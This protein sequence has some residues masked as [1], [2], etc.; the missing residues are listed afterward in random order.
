MHLM[1]IRSPAPLADAGPDR[2]TAAARS[3]YRWLRRAGASVALLLACAAPAA[4]QNLIVNAGFE[5]NPPPANG[6]NIGWSFAPWVLG[7]GDQSNV[8]KVDG[9][10]GFN[11]GNS[12]PQSDASNNGAGAGAGIAQHYAD[13]VGVNDFYQAFTVPICGGAPGQTR[14]ATFSGW[15]STRDNLAGSGAIRIVSGTGLGGTTLA[16]ASAN[17]PVPPLGSGQQPWVRVSGS[18]TVQS[19]AQVSFVVDM[20]NNVNFDEASLV[21]DAV[22]CV[23]APL[24]LRKQ[25]T[26]ATVNDRSVVSATRGGTVVD[27]FTAIANSANELDTDT[28]PL[29]VFEGETIT[30]SEVLAPANV[31]TYTPTLACTGGGT[32]AGNVLTVNNSGTPIVCTYTNTGPPPADLSITKSNAGTSVV[33]GAT[34]TYSIVVSNAG[35]GAANGAVLRDPATP[36]LTCTA[37][38]CGGA[39]GGAVCPAV[40]VAAL[41][42][43]AGVAIPVLPA[44]GAV[45]FSLS[46][47]VN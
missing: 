21:F 5:N 39:S 36:G 44:G 11:Y 37:V 2:T 45:T 8:V 15:F 6:N 32:L 12:G 25:W 10:G 24:T 9:P 42:S 4:A 20:D 3:G 1:T 13:I 7:P 35:P 34:T 19:G 18:V 40:S 22:T 29:T 14:T 30:L 38:T 47:T 28:T 31:A 17:L 43:T 16:Q 27:S 23:T 41:Q 46:C 26:N 33:A